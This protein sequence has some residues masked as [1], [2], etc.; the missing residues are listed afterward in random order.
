MNIIKP[1]LYFNFIFVMIFSCCEKDENTIPECNIENPIEELSWLN[2]VKNSLTN[3]TCAISIIQG[4]YKKK[5][6]FYTMITDPVCNSVFNVILWDCNGQ[7][8]KEYKMGDNEA[9]FNEV[10]IVEVLYTCSE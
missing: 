10:E 7:V 1:I 5:T 9:F 3:C 6:V 4:E 8:I 2:D